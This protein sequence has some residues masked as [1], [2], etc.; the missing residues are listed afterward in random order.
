[1]TNPKF[2]FFNI[3]RQVT[4]MF[5]IKGGKYQEK[6]WNSKSRVKSRQPDGRW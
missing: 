4:V 5:T 3:K 2:E 1:M 6:Y